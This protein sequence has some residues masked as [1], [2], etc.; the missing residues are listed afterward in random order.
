MTDKPD[1]HEP[2]EE[3]VERG[4]LV[5]HDHKEVTDREEAEGLSVE[6]IVAGLAALAN[7]LIRDKYGQAAASVWFHGMFKNAARLAAEEIG[8][9][10]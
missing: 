9:G 2:P 4:R 3:K 8:P 10:N 7:D 5:Y 1:E 6:E